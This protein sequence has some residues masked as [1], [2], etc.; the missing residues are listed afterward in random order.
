MG[1]AI[2]RLAAMRRP[3]HPV[4]EAIEE[5]IQL[6]ADDYGFEIVDIT[7]G[8]PKRNPI[9]T[10]ILDK[11][12]GVTADDCAKMGK[13]FGIL[14]DVRDPIET[15]YQLA[16]SSPGVERP[17]TKPEHFERFAGKQAAIRFIDETDKPKTL[18][19]TLGGL[20]EGD[21]VLEVDGKELLIEDEQIESARLKF[22]WDD[23][24][25]SDGKGG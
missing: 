1:E 7:F 6:M 24:N 8:G 18:T 13:R 19:G 25:V 10:V 23:A 5:D 22:D 15:S 2:C 9:L 16:V 12:D 17:L 20:R 3:K 4:V 21:V 14:M 11:P